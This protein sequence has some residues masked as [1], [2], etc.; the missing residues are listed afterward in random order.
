M[1]SNTEERNLTHCRFFL[2]HE[3]KQR[4]QE[5]LEKEG[6]YDPSENFTSNLYS[7]I[8]KKSGSIK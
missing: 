2:N 5:M 3:E 4:V 7:Y 1:D 8:L 6:L